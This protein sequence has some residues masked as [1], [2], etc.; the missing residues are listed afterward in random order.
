MLVRSVT[1]VVLLA[2]SRDTDLITIRVKPVV[3]RWAL[4]LANPIMHVQGLCFARAGALP[5]LLGEWV[6]ST[7]AAIYALALASLN[8]VVFLARL[9]AL[10]RSKWRGHVVLYGFCLQQT[11]PT[12]QYHQTEWELQIE[13]TQQKI[14]L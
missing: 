2:L 6:G 13:V 4:L 14:T 7:L 5:S 1:Y 9:S 11:V 12:Q 3:F 10:A 8:Y